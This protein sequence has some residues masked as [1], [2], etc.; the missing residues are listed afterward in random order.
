MS[1]NV[2]EYIYDGEKKRRVDILR[3]EDGTFAYREERHFKNVAAEGWATVWDGRSFYAD[4][5][6]A[7]REVIDNVQWIPRAPRNA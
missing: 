1:A 5:A 7:K 2:V 3:R 6:T 4:I